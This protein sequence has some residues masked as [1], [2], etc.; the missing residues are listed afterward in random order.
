MK[1]TGDPDTPKKNVILAEFPAVL[2]MSKERFG[3]YGRF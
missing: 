1:V 2:A 3:L